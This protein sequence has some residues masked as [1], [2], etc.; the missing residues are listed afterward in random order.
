[1]HQ[2]DESRCPDAVPLRLNLDPHFRPCEPR[3]GDELYPNGIFEF[4][5]T[6]LLAHIGASGRHRAERVSLH[7]IPAA[8]NREGLDELTIGAADLSRPVI[9]AEIAPGRHNLIDG[10]HQ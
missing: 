10:H 5:I 2:N 4:N 6:R 7:D 9:L 1:M 3:D 8:G